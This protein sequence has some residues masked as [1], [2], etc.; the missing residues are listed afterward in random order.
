MG[1]MAQAIIRKAVPQVIQKVGVKAGVIQK[2]GVKAGVK[3]VVKQE[4]FQVVDVN[5]ID[6][7]ESGRGGGREAD[8]AVEKLLASAFTLEIGQAIKIPI[9]LRTM[10]E[11][12]S[13]NGNKSEIHQYKGAQTLSKRAAK[14]KDTENPY[15]FRTRRDKSGNMWLFRVE[16]LAEAV[17]VEVSEDEVEA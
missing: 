16:P 7:L 13:A 4:G 14:T 17:A 8:P 11:I 6:F 15:R 12:E 3:P 9:A 10:R 2:V 1:I 5:T